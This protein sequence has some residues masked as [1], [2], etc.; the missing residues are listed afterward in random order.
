MT[1]SR[2]R[3]KRGLC[4][5]CTKTPSYVFISI[6][7][8]CVSSNNGVHMTNSGARFKWGH[9]PSFGRKQTFASTVSQLPNEDGLLCIV[10]CHW[11]MSSFANHFFGLE[12][13]CEILLMN[14]LLS[15]PPIPYLR[16]KQA[17]CWRSLVS[18]HIKGR[19]RGG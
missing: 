11:T 7:A 6:K 8:R 17:P 16:P 10:Q 12:K 13:S 1:N 5:S 2:A 9:F 19:G 15:S 4:T 18:S 14:K 3:F